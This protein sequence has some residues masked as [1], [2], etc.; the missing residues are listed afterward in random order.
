MIDLVE[1]AASLA[2]P[3][4]LVQMLTKMT[5]PL[6]VQLTQQMLQLQSLPVLLLEAEEPP[7]TLTF[8][9]EQPQAR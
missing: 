1:R 2:R 8:L 3:A 7:S 5:E 4:E 6:V 9:L